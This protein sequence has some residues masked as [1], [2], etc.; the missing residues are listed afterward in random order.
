MKTATDLLN[1]RL[2]V[3]VVLADK[4]AANGREI[5]HAIEDR[6]GEH[7]GDPRIYPVLQD[8]VDQGV[9]ERTE[10][11]PTHTRFQLTEDGRAQ[12]DDLHDW[13]TR[14]LDDSSG[15]QTF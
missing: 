9:I 11:N 10:L 1:M 15:Q 13:M 12:L 2:A 14:C 7:I 8:L 5:K 6:A 3:C 4:T